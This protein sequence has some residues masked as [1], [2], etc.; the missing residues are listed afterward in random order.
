MRLR[1]RNLT[2][3][4]GYFYDDHE[5]GRRITTDGNFSRLVDAVVSFRNANSIPVPAFMEAL[6]EDQ[7][8]ARQPIGRCYYTGGLGD[9]VSKVINYTAK[10]VDK[11]LGTQLEKKARGCGGCASRRTRLNA[12][13]R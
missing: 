7:I 2:P 4:G 3:I 11:A 5:A 9:K 1:D 8:C 13:S 12:M 6:I 10:V